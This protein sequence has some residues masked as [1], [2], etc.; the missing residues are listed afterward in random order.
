VVNRDFGDVRNLREAVKLAFQ[1]PNEP[2]E[3]GLTLSFRDPSAEDSG[4]ADRDRLR[5][6]G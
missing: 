3:G 1:G 5:E 2:Q 4:K 6:A